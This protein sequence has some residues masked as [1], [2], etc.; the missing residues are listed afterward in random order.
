MKF[1][2]ISIIAAAVLVIALVAGCSASNGSSKKKVTLAYVAWDSEIA[3]TYVVKEVLEQKLNYEVEL[4]Q[5][6]AGPMWAGISDGSADAMVAAW[7]PTTHASYVSKYNGKYEDLGPNLEGTKIGLVVP[8][9]MDI[10]SIDELND[11]V[12]DTVDH[13]IIGIEPGAGIMMST[14]KVLDSYKLRDKWTLLESS[15]AAM[16]QQLEKAYANKEPI[17]VTGWTPHWMFAKMELKYLEDPQNVYGGDEQIHTIARKGLKE[18]QPEAFTF[19]DQFNWTPD[20]MAAVMIQ[21]QEGETP[22]AAAKA[23]VEQNTSKVDAWVA[24]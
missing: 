14:E 10:N 20:D 2:R 11:A 23:W 7:L 21:I 6:D 12:G 18:D 8:K 15:S 24:E 1:N 22:E 19:L 4:M 5:V 16:T 17:V 3:S 9:Y 13:T